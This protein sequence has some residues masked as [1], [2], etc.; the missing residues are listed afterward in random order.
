VLKLKPFRRVGL[1][2]KL[3]DSRLWPVNPAHARWQS[4]RPKTLKAEAK[5]FGASEAAGTWLGPI[6]DA[7]LATLNKSQWT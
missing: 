6:R 5:H 3:N 1:A 4:E 2:A 7:S